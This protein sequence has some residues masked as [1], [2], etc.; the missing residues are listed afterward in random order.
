MT[1]M[2]VAHMRAKPGMV[3]EHVRLHEA[4]PDRDM[5]GGKGFRIVRTGERDFIVLGAWDSMDSIAAARPA[6]IGHL[7]RLPPIL[8]D[9]G[10]G[11]GV[12]EPRS[13]EVAL[14]SPH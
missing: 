8:A 10:S 12:T 4:M 1:A 14:Q 5:P 7:D 13:G 3:D 6:M 11:R 2:T 9:L